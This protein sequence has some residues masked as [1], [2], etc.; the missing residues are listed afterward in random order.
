MTDATI[1]QYGR[2]EQRTLPLPQ[3][4]ASSTEHAQRVHMG[5]V[6][7]LWRTSHSLCITTAALAQRGANLGR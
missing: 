5:C 1:A 2:E 6:G 3:W 4:E 7:P